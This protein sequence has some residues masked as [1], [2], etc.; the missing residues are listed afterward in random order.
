MK[1][2]ICNKESKLL[3]ESVFDR[4]YLICINCKDLERMHKD[5]LNSIKAIK[6]AESKGLYDFDGIG[7]PL[8]FKNK[9]C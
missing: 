1:C 7:F 8:D 5:Y 6:D 4:K 3:F 9:R 2:H